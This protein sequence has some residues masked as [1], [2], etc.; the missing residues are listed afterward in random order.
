MG[1]IMP[2]RKCGDQDA[3]ESHECGTAD[4]IAFSGYK[5]FLSD[6]L[7]SSRAEEA[8]AD[9]VIKSLRDLKVLSEIPE[10]LDPMDW[11]HRTADHRNLIDPIVR[12]IIEALRQT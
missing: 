11:L 4:R 7:N 12:E 3:R 1:V 5:E 2:C 6:F 10:D 8:I 9:A